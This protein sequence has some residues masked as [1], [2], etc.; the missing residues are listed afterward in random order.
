M[1]RLAP[2]RLFLLVSLFVAA[3]V[4]AQPSPCPDALTAAET[5]YREQAYAAVELPVFDC[6]YHPEATVEEQVAA[7]RLLALSLI[8]QDR[9]PEARETIIKILGVDYAYVAD[10]TTDLPL[11]VGLVRVTREQLQIDSSVPPLRVAAPSTP[12]ARASTSEPPSDAARALVDANTA[13][14]EELDTVPGIGPA[15]AGRIVAY[16]TQNGP[17][18]SVADLE[19]VRGIGPR[20]LER[21]SPYLTVTEG[22]VRGVAAVD[23]APAEETSAPPEPLVN[24]NTASAEVLDTLDG[25]GPALAARIIEFRETFGPFQ[26]VGDVVQ[27][28]GIGPRTLQ[29]FAHRVTVE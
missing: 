23:A 3:S 1:I 6:V 4:A 26:S 17:F 12:P 5:Q 19:A 14:A 11:Y 7:Y 10:L 20:T 29:G 8:K 24:L 15:I 28:R 2:H 18:G 16:R 27:V 25:I 21:M 9:L 22:D 13:S